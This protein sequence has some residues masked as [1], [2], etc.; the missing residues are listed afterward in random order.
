MKLNELEAQVKE[1]NSKPLYKTINEIEIELSDAE[2]EESIKACALMI[3]QQ[4]NPELY[5]KLD[6]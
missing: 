3:H 2:Y 4:Q 6:A 1:E 5:K